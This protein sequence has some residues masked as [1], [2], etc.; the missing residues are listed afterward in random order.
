MQ[1]NRRWCSSRGIWVQRIG[2][3]LN[4]NGKI[5]LLL[6]PKLYW[7]CI[8][9]IKHTKHETLYIFRN[10]LKKSEVISNYCNF[11]K[12]KKMKHQYK[13]CVCLYCPI[14]LFTTTIYLGIFNRNHYL[15]SSEIKSTLRYWYPYNNLYNMFIIHDNLLQFS[16]IL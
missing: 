14:L 11:K 8:L 13:M 15:K 2:T 5:W 16:S 6:S 3:I 1:V 9:N 10:S 7:F 12:S 4:I